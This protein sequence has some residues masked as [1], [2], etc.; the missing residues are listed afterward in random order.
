LKHL[1]AVYALSQ[2]VGATSLLDY[3]CG[4]GMAY[5]ADGKFPGSAAAMGFDVPPGSNLEDLLGYKVFKYDPAVPEFA[6]EPNGYFDL[7]VCSDVLE[8]IPEED[9]DWV[10]EQL[11]WRARKALFVTVGI[12]PAKKTLPNGENAHVTVKPEEWWREKIEKA[13]AARPELIVE[14][15]VG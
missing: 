4:K 11:V 15:L 2:K 7:V 12:Y 10:L 13:S 1:K 6:T 9:I 8:H 3:G 5:K 14:V